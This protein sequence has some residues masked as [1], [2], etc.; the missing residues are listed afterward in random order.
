MFEHDSP[1][2]QIQNPA[3]RFT[4][5]LFFVIVLISSLIGDS[6]ILIAS[7]RY[8]AFKLNKLIVVVIQHIAVCD[9]ISS[10]VFVF[11]TMVSLAANKWVLGETFAYFM[12]FPNFHAYQA[13]GFLISILTTMKVLL[14][15]FPV[16]SKSWTKRQIHL[17][18]SSAWLLTLVHP[19]LTLETLVKCGVYF[20][21]S[22]Y[23]SQPKICIIN[24]IVDAG[25]IIFRIN[26]FVP[27]FI[28]I[29]TSIITTSYLFKS[30]A[31]SREA[32]GRVRW[33]GIVTVTLTAA[34]FIISSAPLAIQNLNV[35]PLL[36]EGTH[37]ALSQFMEFITILNIMSNFYIYCLTV[38][39]F[40]EFIKSKIFSILRR[41]AHVFTVARVEDDVNNV[42]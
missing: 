31:V 24:P 22:V 9:L 39:S 21:Y 30:R 13:S 26:M 2:N 29:I 27:I 34:L 36:S 25:G 40:R 4:W 11:P 38:P 42:P 16:R 1:E 15:K 19:I 3:E 7:I 17:I 5:V 10:L 14:L 12:V 33:H 8:N 23:N 28:V 37:I 35:I 32:G 20:S 18:C 41:W 6:L